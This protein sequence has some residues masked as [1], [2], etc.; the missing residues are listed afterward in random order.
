ML[1]L[2]AITMEGK[3]EYFNT[4]KIISIQL[5]GKNQNKVKILM[6]SG[7]YWIIQSNTMQIMTLENMIKD[8]ETMTE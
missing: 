8:V 5:L 4:S 7:M 3:T 1:F 2:K 6:G